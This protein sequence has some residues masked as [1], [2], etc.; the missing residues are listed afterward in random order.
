MLVWRRVR[1][2]RRLTEVVIAQLVKTPD[3][4]PEKL[5]A[6]QANGRQSQGAVTPEGLERSRDSRIRHGFYVQKPGEALR[7]LG[8]AAQAQGKRRSKGRRRR[9][10]NAK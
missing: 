2:F 5:A 8:A 1:C 3:M 10:K 7:V 9:Q 4:T 6:N